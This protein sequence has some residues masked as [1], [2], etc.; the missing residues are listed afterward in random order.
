MPELPEVQTIV[1]DLNKKIKG[2]TIADFWSD[3]NKG[4][5]MPFAKFAAAIK[6]KKIVKVDRVGKNILVKLAG[7]KTIIVHLRMTGALIMQRG[8]HNIELDKHVHHIFYFKS[9]KVLEFSDVRKFGSLELAEVGLEAESK[10]M[11]NLG[12]DVLNKKFT[13]KKFDDV[14]DSR[15]TNIKQLLLDQTKIAGIGNIYA[16]EILFVAGVSPRRKAKSLH[17]EEKRKIFQAIAKII[18]KAIKM[19]G[20][21]I[22]DYRDA[23]GKQGQF[24]KMLKVYG[25][26]G[27]KCAKCG[28]IIERSV[29]GQRSTFHC[30]I[31][32]K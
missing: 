25:R 26:A 28:T 20:T 18:R 27:K 8:K 11:R 30:P 10:S 14:L 22:S 17:A 4:I 16:N 29:I 32:Q 6:N 5:R 12:I 15:K 31:C 21:S 13:F 19:R 24:Q 23:G 1:D 2:E 9:G 3:W 7:G